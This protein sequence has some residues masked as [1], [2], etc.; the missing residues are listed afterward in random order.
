MLEDFSSTLVTSISLGNCILQ[1]VLC[2]FKANRHDR[3]LKKLLV[4]PEPS[5]TESH[6]NACTMSGLLDALQSLVSSIQNFL[7]D[8]LCLDTAGTTNPS[9]LCKHKPLLQWTKKKWGMRVLKC[10]LQ[11]TSLSFFVLHQKSEM[12]GIQTF[13]LFSG[14]RH[15]IP[16]IEWSIPLNAKDPLF[17]SS[18]Q[19]AVQLLQSEKNKGSYRNSPNASSRRLNEGAV[20]SFDNAVMLK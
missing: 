4:K 6:V 10:H 18:Y 1:K 20:S 17:L 9:G 8:K 15:D 19:H 12:D 5:D 7:R 13:N 16:L 14:C 2:E 11:Q 3:N